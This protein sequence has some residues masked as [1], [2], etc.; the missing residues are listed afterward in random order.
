MGIVIVLTCRPTGHIDWSIIHGASPMFFK[1]AT[2]RC[3][4]MASAHLGD[5]ANKFFL[6]VMKCNY[7]EIKLEN[8]RS[9][10]ST[11]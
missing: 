8:V 7:C 2:A 1:D 6:D 10:V 11:I 9:I 4:A 5:L 3:R